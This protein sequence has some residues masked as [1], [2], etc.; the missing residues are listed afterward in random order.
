[1]VETTNSK[2][3]KSSDEEDYDGC[4]GE[5]EDSTMTMNIFKGRIKT[6]KKFHC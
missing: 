3:A 6:S 2:V 1:M 5:E 4:N